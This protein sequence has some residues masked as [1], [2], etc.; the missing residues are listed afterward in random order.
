VPTATELLIEEEREALARNALLLG[1]TV[2]K[3]D[4]ENFVVGMTARDS[5]E[6]YVYCNCTGYAATPPA[7]HWYDPATGERDLPK[8]TPKGGAFF[9]SNGVIC[10]PWNRLAYKGVD[11]RGP[12]EDWT[13]ANWHTNPKNGAC[14][15]LSAMAIRIYCELNAKSFQGRMG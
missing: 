2:E 7:W 3:I 12:H 14:R 4:A 10:A 13:L 5:T 6:F 11:G 15:T 8:L 1:W 9:H